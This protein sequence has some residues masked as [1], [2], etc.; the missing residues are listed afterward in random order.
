MDILARAEAPVAAG[1]R[2]GAA[3]TGRVNLV[4]TRDVAEAARAALIDD[5]SPDTQRAYHLTGPGPV[6]MPDVADIPSRLLGRSV[7]YEHRT[8][9]EHR[10]ILIR[11]GLNEAIADLL[12]GLDLMVAQSVLAETTANFSDLTGRIPR[13]DEVWLRDHLAAFEKN[14]DQ[15]R[16]TAEKTG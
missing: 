16:I 5:R 14:S 11:S 6:S 15:A 3:G 4:D 12:L 9:A 7:A 1:Q 13:S 8:P 2:G 10:V